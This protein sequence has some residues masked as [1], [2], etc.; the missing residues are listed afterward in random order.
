MFWRRKS[1]D[2][3]P[4]SA[5]DGHTRGDLNS[6]PVGEAALD[7]AVAILRAFGRHA[8]EI[9][10]TDMATFRRLCD[11]WGQHLAIGA[12]HPEAGTGDTAIGRRERDFAG[13]RRF[14]VKRRQDEAT[15][16]AKSLGD[17]REVIADLTE[18]FANSLDNDQETSRQV[19]DQ[20]VRLRSA[21]DQT[22]MEIVRQEV[23][24]VAD[25]LTNLIDQHSQRV[26]VQLAELD[27]KILQL[28]EE[29]QELKYESS[30]DPLTRVFN[31]GAFDRTFRRLHR[32]NVVSVQ[33][34]SILL[35]DLDNLKQINDAY[36][37]Q[38]GDEAL[39]LFSDCLVR[40][41]PRRSDFI[42]RY[43]GDEFVAILPQT[44]AP[45]SERLVRR[46]LDAV[47]RLTVS[48][49]GQSFSITVSIGLAELIPGEDADS[50]LER[51]DRA[52]LEAKANGRDT[53]CI[54]P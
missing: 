22:S 30:L 21:A 25:L 8:F 36:G 27:N 38:A 19:G 24:S 34:S 13:A 3:D 14:F 31:R 48:R 9:A 1:A 42:A 28:S 29:L 10:G 5:D 7:T 12:E 4:P 23:V 39:R 26:R 47:H 52:L 51:A 49:E 37:H 17:L 53:L 18:R 43:G 50:W 11:A 6:D 41:F 16:L 20:V 45:Q 35:I 32:I 44:P 15:F 54:A 40:N 33:A 46:F 2:D